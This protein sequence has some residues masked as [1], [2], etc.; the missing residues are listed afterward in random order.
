MLHFKRKMDG[1]RYERQTTQ[2]SNPAERNEETQ[3]RQRQRQSKTG[4]TEK[5]DG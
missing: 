5:D 2:A 1:R 3:E 4:T